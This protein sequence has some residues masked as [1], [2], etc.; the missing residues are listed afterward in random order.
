[1]ELPQVDRVTGEKQSEL[2]DVL[3]LAFSTDPIARFGMPRA[4]QYLNG[5]RIVFGGFSETAIE[6]GCAWLCT[7]HGGAAMWLPPGVHESEEGMD[8]M[9][10][11]IE[12]ER[13]DEFLGLLGQMEASHPDR[14]HW[15]LGFIGVDI[16]RQGEG[17]G[18]ALMKTSLQPVDEAGDLAYLVSSNI[19]NVPLY[20]RFGFE[21]TSEIQ[22]GNSPVVYPMVREAR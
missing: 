22:V 16:D 2:I 11:F 8:E 6:S 14:P 19:R 17:L 5:M 1:M 9:P 3:M 21:V 13:M 4:N 10:Q 7:D 20:E 12:P 15:Y 18:S